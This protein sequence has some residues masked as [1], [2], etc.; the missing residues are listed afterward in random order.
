MAD[1][2]GTI[3][4]NAIAKMTG[5][6]DQ[7]GG[8]VND[9]K[10]YAASPITVDGLT[11]PITSTDPSTIDA[12]RAAAAATQ[13][14]TFRMWAS[15]IYT[16]TKP[17]LDSVTYNAVG[18]APEF[19]GAEP[20]INIP[21]APSAALPGAPGAAPEF[22]SPSI[23]DAPT[24]SL[25]E[26]PSFENVSIPIIPEVI[27]PEFDSL[28]PEDEEL[29]EPT[30]EF[31]YEEGEYE[32]SL[33]DPLR[34]QLLDNL[35]NGGYGIEDADEQRLWERARDREAMVTEASIQDTI[36]RT[37]ARGFQLPPGAMQALI[38]AAQQSS[39]EKMSSLSREI[40]IKKADLYV[41]NRKFTIQQ[42]KEVEDMLYKYWSFAQERVLN[43]AKYTAEFGQQL[44][45]AKVARYQA[46]MEGYKAKAQVFDTLVR[47]VLANLESYKIKMEGARLSVEVQKLHADVYR[48]QIEGATALMGIY[49]VEMEAARIQAE[50]EKIKLDAFRSSVEAYTAQVGAKSAEFGMY[51]AQI[52]GEMSKVEI[53]K[54]QAQAFGER[55]RAYSARVGAADAEAKTKIAVANL[56]L[57]NY[58]A[59]IEG[60]RA[61]LNAAEI[62]I[63]AMSDKYTN[64]LRKYT[65]TVDAYSKVAEEN[66]GVAKANADIALSGAKVTSSHILGQGQ[67]LVSHAQMASTAAASGINGLATTATA[68]G[69][70]VSGI[71]ATIT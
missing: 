15:S 23:P 16:P 4:S 3:Q 59:E 70:Q 35:V 40:M 1:T 69:N 44:Y 56:Q 14:P 50:V 68:Y 6:V 18:D 64:D 31:F 19:V 53:Y 67:L 20:I 28:P 54:A 21:T 7:I 71:L 32:R 46:K 47:T 12:I 27:F 25:P 48:T 51:K 65:A 43:T 10:A 30:F 11:I 49:K 57:D 29:L 66:I 22:F 37:A 17:E 24:V 61:N 13:P 26:A 41:E 62:D 9:L 34:S 42:V 38:E 36:R 52:D 5:L 45:N 58:R 63:K 8:F 2:P 55:I 60:Y 39:L 33:L